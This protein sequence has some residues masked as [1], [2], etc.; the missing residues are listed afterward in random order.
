MLRGGGARS[1]GIYRG[2]H[3]C[4][5]SHLQHVHGNALLF[6]IQDNTPLALKRAITII[7]HQS[8]ISRL[9]SLN[10]GSF[11]R[12]L[13]IHINRITDFLKTLETKGV[14]YY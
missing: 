9:M 3:Q 10:G 14:Y 5:R 2:L 8:S 7:Y 13:L 1:R 4:H 12:R 11:L 6:V